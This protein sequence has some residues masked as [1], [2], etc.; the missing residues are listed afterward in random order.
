M[1]D[2]CEVTDGIDGDLIVC[3]LLVGRDVGSMQ[4]VDNV[5]TSCLLVVTWGRPSWTDGSD[6]G[7]RFERGPASSVSRLLTS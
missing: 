2:L 1:I 4:E 6:P 5:L 3:V 7:Q